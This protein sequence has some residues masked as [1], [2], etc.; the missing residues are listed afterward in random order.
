MNDMIDWDRTPLIP[1]VT[2]DADTKEVLMLAYVNKEA[3]RLTLESGF[4]HYYSRSRNSLWK[5]GEGSGNI[6]TVIEIRLDCDADTLLYL[7]KQTGVACHTGNRS[8]VYRKI[9]NGQ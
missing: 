8:C 5:K 2:Q 9:G 3:L 1:A 4:A 6:Q 7:V